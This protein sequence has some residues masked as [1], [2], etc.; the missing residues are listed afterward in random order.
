VDLEIVPAAALL[1]A[2]GSVRGG[3][4]LVSPAAYVAAFAASG[5]AR[6]FR[7]RARDLFTTGVA[8]PVSP[9]ASPEGAPT[10]D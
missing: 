6:V 1:W 2:G 3:A 8:I 4:R 7:L 10:Y 9:D 5:L